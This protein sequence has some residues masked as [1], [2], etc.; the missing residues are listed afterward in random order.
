M[1]TLDYGNLTLNSGADSLIDLIK[2][3]SKVL[4]KNHEYTSRD[5][6]LKGVLCDITVSGGNGAIFEIYGMPN[7]WK[8]RN[9][10]RKFHFLRDHMFREAG[11]TKSE[12]GKYGKTIRPYLDQRHANSLNSTELDVGYREYKNPGGGLPSDMAF[13]PYKG[14]EWTR[15]NFATVPLYSQS[16]PAVGGPEQ[17]LP[18]VDSWDIH[19]ADANQIEDASVGAGSPD[20]YTYNSV[21]VIH[22]YNL[23]RQA[24]QTQTADTTLDGP[25]NPLAALAVSGNQAGGEI[26]DIAE[27]QELELPP[28]DLADDGDSVQITQLDRWAFPSTY[29]STHVFRNVFIPAGMMRIASSVEASGFDVRVDVIA[30][31]ECRDMA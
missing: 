17:Q 14:G 31:V 4:S 18:P 9:G 19:L 23:D 10:M 16:N 13:T 21:G 6:H 28:Y 22:S 25:S 8:L 2:D 11:V 7:T 29:G 26:I 3:Q 30:N 24:V 12:M 5:G 1:I 27:D 15:S 20:T